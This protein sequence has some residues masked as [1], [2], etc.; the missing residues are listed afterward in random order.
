MPGKRAARPT[1]TAGRS[2]A[3]VAAVVTVLA[4]VAGLAALT[5]WWPP[6]LLPDDRDGG[7]AA[8]G[9]TPEESRPPASS[10]SAS[11][12]AR[13]GSQSA[14]PV[15][16]TGP[17]RACRA[18][19]RNAERVVD[20]AN[21]GVTR[22]RTHVQART[23]MLAGRISEA[24]MEKLW[25]YTQERGPKDQRRFRTVL[26]DYRPPAPCRRLRD[27]PPAQRRLAD[28]CTARAGRATRAV[29]AARAAMRDWRDHLA[30]MAAFSDGKMT[31]SMAQ[32]RWVKAW[33]AAPANIMAFRDT[34]A[35]LEQAPVCVDRLAHR[36]RD[37]ERAQ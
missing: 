17:L 5:G 10:G 16:L 35:A 15:R 9:R 2:A 25:V 12:T 7:S 33:N 3:V 13:P 36:D 32:G 37:A 14:G 22:W 24:R 26:R 1:R 31:A 8:P 21:G 6:S 29:R 11:P 20:V 28:S 19:V 30:T 27:V 23:D 34:R 18:R 4:L